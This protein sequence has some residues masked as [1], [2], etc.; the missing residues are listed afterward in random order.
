MPSFQFQGQRIVF[1]EFGGGPA[2]VTTAGARG[3][4]ARSAPARSRPLI[5]LHGL[6][7]SQEMHK[8]LAEA[9][10][11]RGNR[12][13]TLDLLGHGR[14]DRPRDMWRYSMT[15]YGREIVALMDHLEID[16][17]VVMGT[18]LGAN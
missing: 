15:T 5:L 2:A 8:P 11:A 17:A 3:G 18:S 1:E 6:L 12:V 4:T 10:A 9:L 13:I 7:L 14:S 16:E